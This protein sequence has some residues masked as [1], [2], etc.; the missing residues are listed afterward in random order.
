MARIKLS[1]LFYVS[2]SATHGKGLFAKCAI[3]KGDYMGTY[4][5]PV[6][7]DMDTGGPHVLW[8]EGEDGVWHGRDGRNILRYMNHHEEPCAEFDSFDLFALRDIA[9]DSEVFIHYGDEFSD[10]IEKL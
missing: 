3:R 6:C 10:S 4:K 9:I 5:G 7:Y 8:V 1:S 2:E